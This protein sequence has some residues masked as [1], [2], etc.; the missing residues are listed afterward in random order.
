MTQRRNRRAGVEDRWRKADGT[1]SANDGK[2][3]RWR[4]RYVDD[5]AKEH[6]KAFGRKADAQTWLNEQTTSLVN[7]TYVD[8]TRGSATFKQFYDDWSPRQVWAPTTRTNANYVAKTVP[9]NG[10]QMGRIRR[11]DVEAWVKAM[12]DAGLQP[13]TIKTRFV[14]ARG[15]FNAARL[16]RV[17]GV[18]PTQHVAL[19]RTRKRAAAMTIPTPA[20]VAALVE[21]ADGQLRLYVQ[22]C[23]FAG[24]R[25]GEA[26]GVQVGDVNFLG[27]SLAVTRQIQRDGNKPRQAP[28]KFGSERVVYLP[29]DLVTAI[30]AH[31]AQWTPDGEPDRWLFT[32][33]DGVPWFDNR[34]GWRWRKARAEAGVD[35]RLHDLRHF[36]AS[37]LISSGCDVVTV[38]RA[39]GHASATTT[40]ST[41]SHL[42]PDAEDRT[43]AAT[44]GLMTAVDGAADSLRTGAPKIGAELGVQ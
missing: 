40:L 20:D 44:A 41:Y 22:L 14:I 39:L 37:G 42:W 28:P 1:P 6:S 9:F 8:P 38:Q 21:A 29:D 16:D 15:I 23:A 7:G 26:A 25:L 3:M 35:C 10:K 43:R 30:S 2:G 34:V 11:S 36:Y 24:L 12:V 31:I 19:P 18:D 5:D 13:T 17:I 33:D 4:A 27:R 32:D